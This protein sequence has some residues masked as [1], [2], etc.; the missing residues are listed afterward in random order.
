MMK[1]AETFIVYSIYFLIWWFTVGSA[2]GTVSKCVSLL[3][4]YIQ[5]KS[6]I[7]EYF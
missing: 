3:T 2:K 1:F 6:K 7:L 4:F 5:R